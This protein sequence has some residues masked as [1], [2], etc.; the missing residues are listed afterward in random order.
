MKK[1]EP[2]V[3]VVVYFPPQLKADLLKWKKENKTTL[4]KWARLKAEET[5]RKG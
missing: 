4:T 2:Q 5:I 1:L 3:R